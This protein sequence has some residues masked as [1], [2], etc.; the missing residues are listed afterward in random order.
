MKK[1]IASLTVAAS[2]LGGAAGAIVFAPGPLSAQTEAG[3]EAPVDGE[4]RPERGAWLA[5]VL[6]G[7]VEDGTLTAEQAE[8]VET[9]IAEARPDRH[10]GRRGRGPG[11]LEA[12]EELTDLLGLE[13]A[14]I[15]EA[16]RSGDS[17]ADIAAAQGVDAGDV[18][19]ALVERAAERIDEAVAEGR[20]D[21]A[22]AADRLAE[23]TERITAMVDGDAGFER[24]G[25]GGGPLA[26]G[27]HGD[28]GDH[29][30]R[31]GR[32]F[33]HGAFGG[34]GGADEEPGA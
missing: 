15:A 12:V 10:E 34:M 28:R 31:G 27:E 11:R 17:L 23:V 18:V 6:E 26:D 24:R 8:A 9:A 1:S 29:G 7:L 20:I 14:E 32:R 22:D 3:T 30:D 33:G 25:H 16:L 5:E 4:A 13:A 21:E 2:L 19:D